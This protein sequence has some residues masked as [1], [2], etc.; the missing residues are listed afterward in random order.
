MP[1]SQSPNSTFNFGAYYTI[2]TNFSTYKFKLWDQYMASQ[3]LF[4]NITDSPTNQ[5][6]PAYNIL[7]AS[8]NLKTISLDNMIPGLKTA[9]LTLSVYNLLN[10]EFNSTEYISSGGYFGTS[11]GGYVIANPGAPR[12]FFLNVTMKF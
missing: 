1:I 6:M 4:N 8:I 2:P 5:T 9:D 3:Y 7:N 10:K 11:Y 12:M